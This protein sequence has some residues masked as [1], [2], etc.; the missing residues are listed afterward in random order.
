[1]LLCC[2]ANGHALGHASV[3]RVWEY[4]VVLAAVTQNG[5]ALQ[6]ERWCK[7]RD[8]RANVMSTHDRALVMAAVSQRSRSPGRST[9]HSDGNGA[10]V[11]G[12]ASQ[13]LRADRAIAIAA[14]TWEPQALA[15]ASPTLKSDRGVVLAALAS[16]HTRPYDGIQLHLECNN[17]LAMVS[18]DLRMDGEVLRLVE[19]VG[20]QDQRSFITAVLLTQR[21]RGAPPDVSSALRVVLATKRPRLRFW[22]P[23]THKWC[24][25]KQ[26]ACVL[27]VLV[28]EVR[29]D[30]QPVGDG[31]L[32]S[33]PHDLW[34]LLLEFVRPSELGNKGSH[35]RASDGT[36]AVGAPGR[37]AHR[38]SRLVLIDSSDSESDDVC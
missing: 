38:G 3:A 4:D 29:V 19:V 2:R 25:T 16:L 18:P 14:V 20:D 23:M 5:Q 7:T 35:G 11:L 34:L 32:L 8:G 27:T 26:R 17:L 13:T 33:L 12:Y 37:P 6:H 9:S 30:Q 28:A 1:M 36:R 22:H 31:H 15:H 24:T 10:A 21:A